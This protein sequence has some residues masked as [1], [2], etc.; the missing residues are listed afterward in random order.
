MPLL[1]VGASH[2]PANAFTSFAWDQ[3]RHRPW[4]V[5]SGT[6]DARP[7]L[8]RHVRIQAPVADVAG[9]MTVPSRYGPFVKYG[10]IAPTPWLALFNAGCLL[11]QSLGCM[12]SLQAHLADQITS[13]AFGQFRWHTSVVVLPQSWGV[14]RVQPVVAAQ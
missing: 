11:C 10:S 6:S 5:F 7:A 3:V 1:E 4:G 9:F 12:T 8:T 2:R 14:G 13:G